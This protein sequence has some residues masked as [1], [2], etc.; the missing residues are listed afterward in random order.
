MIEN[1]EKLPTPGGEGEQPGRKRNKMR[2]RQRKPEGNRM[3]RLLAL[4]AP[5]VVICLLT[6][7]NQSSA[8]HDAD[9]KALQENE[10]QWNQDYAAKD[11]DKIV[12]HYADDAVLL[13]PGMAPTV[14][15]DAIRNIVK[16]MVSDPAM[17]LKFQA[18][19]IDVAKSGDMATT[20][21]TYTMIMTN[22]GTNQPF[23]DH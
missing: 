2:C 23:T 19:K 7:C 12:S 5:L 14:G 3:K 20:Q 11:A 18:S 22:P 4:C 21:G 6:A 17:S 10:N 8:N 16:E 9:I 1:K 13:G 15:K